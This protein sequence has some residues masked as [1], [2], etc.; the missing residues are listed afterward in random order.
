MNISLI[1]T[2]YNWQEALQLSLQSA[3]SQTHL[4]QKTKDKNKLAAARLE[5]GSGR[6]VELRPQAFEVLRQLALNAGRRVASRYA[7]LDWEQFR[8]KR[9]R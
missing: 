4:T 2:T 9:R 7:G 6:A 1:I 5:D 8:K 3:L